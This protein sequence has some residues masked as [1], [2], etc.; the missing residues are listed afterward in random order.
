MIVRRVTGLEY[1][2]NKKGDLVTDSLIILARRG[3]ISLSCYM[4]LV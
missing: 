3:N 4:D 1:S 2:R